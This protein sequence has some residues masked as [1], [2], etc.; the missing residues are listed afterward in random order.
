MSK[1]SL[2][3]ARDG[4]A[5][6]HTPYIEVYRS[7]VVVIEEIPDR[8][9]EEKIRD[10]VTITEKKQPETV[11]KEVEIDQV[12]DIEEDRVQQVKKFK[13]EKA[14]DKDTLKLVKSDPNAKFKVGGKDAVRVQNPLIYSADQYNYIDPRSNQNYYAEDIYADFVANAKIQKS[15]PTWEGKTKE[16][17]N[18]FKGTVND[19]KEEKYELPQQSVLEIPKP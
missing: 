4:Y 15:E 7:G 19:F 12:I 13:V 17:Y 3:Q 9:T 18:S 16:G 10:V 6:P 14:E 5:I 1:D 11:A 8:Q 2:K